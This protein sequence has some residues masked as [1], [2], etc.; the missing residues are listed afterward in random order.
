MGYLCTVPPKFKRYGVVM[1]A[2]RYIS[3]VLTHFEYLNR[4]FFNALER[5]IAVEGKRQGVEGWVLWELSHIDDQIY[6][7]WRSTNVLSC[8]SHPSIN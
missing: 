6:C 4:D 5:R 3:K 7:K 1:L 2:H 8:I